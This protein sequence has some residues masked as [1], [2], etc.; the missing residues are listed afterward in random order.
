[1]PARDIGTYTACNGLALHLKDNGSNW[2]L[3]GGG[4]CSAEISIS[5]GKNV[6]S[7]FAN[8]LNGNY[9][10]LKVQLI[11]EVIHRL[12]VSKTCPCDIIRS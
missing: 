12:C 7:R 5:K 1:M 6:V 10:V 2:T 4:A 11:R 8:K 3:D 9:P